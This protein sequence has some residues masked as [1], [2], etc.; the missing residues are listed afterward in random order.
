MQVKANMGEGTRDALARSML[1]EKLG[2]CSGPNRWSHNPDAGPDATQDGR[3]NLE[4]DR[5]RHAM[6]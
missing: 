3:R 2:G 6:K 4:P 5:D 1:S